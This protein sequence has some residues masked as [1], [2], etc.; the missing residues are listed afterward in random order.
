MMNIIYKLG[1]GGGYWKVSYLIS[2]KRIQEYFTKNILKIN[3]ILIGWIRWE[4][5]RPLASF[6]TAPTSTTARCFSF[7]TSVSTS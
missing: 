1:V 7:A 4:L 6:T 5:V 3:I 2:Q